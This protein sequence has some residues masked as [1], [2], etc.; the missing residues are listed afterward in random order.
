MIKIKN[1][2]LVE[3]F[4]KI[5]KIQNFCK[6]VEIKKNEYGGYDVFYEDKNRDIKVEN[7]YIWED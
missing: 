6:L 5:I 7:I 3:L 1:Y 4:N 2:C